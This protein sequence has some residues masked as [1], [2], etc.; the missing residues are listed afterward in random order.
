MGSVARR[1]DSAHKDVDNGRYVRIRGV[2]PREIYAL[3]QHSSVKRILE[4]VEGALNVHITP[5]D[6]SSLCIGKNQNEAFADWPDH[7]GDHGLHRLRQYLRL[8]QK[9]AR[10]ALLFFHMRIVVT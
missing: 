8:R 1:L 2:I 4:C 10:D 9:G 3:S 6:S 7:L 5:D